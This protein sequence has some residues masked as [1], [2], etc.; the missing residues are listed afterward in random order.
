VN[1]TGH[2]WS[3]T[4]VSANARFVQGLAPAHRAIFDRTLAEAMA[5]LADETAAEEE[6]LLK[7]MQAERGVQ[8]VRPDV[9]AFQATAAPI[10]AR[11]AAERCRPGILD[12]IAKAAE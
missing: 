2:V 12:D 6:N 4:V 8:I 9:A 1:L 5:W 11:F 10:V 3:Y 7:R